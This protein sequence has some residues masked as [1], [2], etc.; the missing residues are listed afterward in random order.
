M[1]EEELYASLAPAFAELGVPLPEP[2][3][4][5]DFLA[6]TDMMAFGLVANWLLRL[7]EAAD[8]Q[9]GQVLRRLGRIGQRLREQIESRYRV[10]L[11]QIALEEGEPAFLRELIRLGINGMAWAHWQAEAARL[12]IDESFLDEC[13]QTLVKF[14]WF[15]LAESDATTDYLATLTPLL[16]VQRLQTTLQRQAQELGITLLNR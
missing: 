15:E 5:H 9:A 13:V 10:W 2:D 14:T 16:L 6:L 7:L 8:L 3:Q 1:S 4:A 11:L 12:R